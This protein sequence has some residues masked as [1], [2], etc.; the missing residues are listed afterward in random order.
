MNRYDRLGT[1]LPRDA[2]GRI[3]NADGVIIGDLRDWRSEDRATRE[4]ALDA[5][6]AAMDR[7]AALPYEVGTNASVTAQYIAQA[8]PEI[9]IVVFASNEFAKRGNDSC[10]T[11]LRAMAMRMAKRESEARAIATRDAA[12]ARR[13]AASQA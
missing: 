2:H 12:K 6:F 11:S 1:P 4:A 7:R 9:G 10:A 8:S 5:C 13:I 3:V